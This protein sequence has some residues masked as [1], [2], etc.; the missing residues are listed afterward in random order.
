MLRSARDDHRRILGPE[1]SPGAVQFHLDCPLKRLPM[2]LERGMEVLRQVPAVLEPGVDPEVFS[3]ALEAVRH[4][5]NRVMDLPG[6]LG[7]CR[8]SDHLCAP[9]ITPSE[10]DFLRAFYG[11]SLSY[12]SVT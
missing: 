12:S 2:L 1:G 5:V 6:G 7:V 4:A 3:L 9:P 10:G 11:S 8:G